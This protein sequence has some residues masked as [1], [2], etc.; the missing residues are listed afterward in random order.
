ML[1]SYNGESALIK[2]VYVRKKYYGCWDR[3]SGTSAVWGGKF[4]TLAC[5]KPKPSELHQ[6]CSGGQIFDIS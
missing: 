5:Y 1:I 2:K 3:D 4:R 6:I